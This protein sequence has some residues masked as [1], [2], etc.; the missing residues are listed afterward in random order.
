MQ[1]I[2]IPVLAVATVSLGARTATVG[3]TPAETVRKVY[4]SVT[5]SKGVPAV[6]LTAADVTVKENGK[7]YP[8]A[9]LEPAKAPMHIAIVVDDGG[10]GAFQSAVAELLQKTFGKA[11]YRISMLTPQATTVIDFTE[12][13]DGLKGAIG[14]L[15]LRGRQR[16][17]GDHLLTG[18]SEAAKALQQ[19]NA[20]RPII[21]VM[22]LGSGQATEIDP[23]AVLS[24]LRTSGASLNVLYFSGADIGEVMI[25]GPK[26]SGGRIEEANAGAPIAPAAGKLAEIL[27]KQY[28]LTYKLPDGVKMSDKVAVETS[29]KGVTLT[30]PTRIPDK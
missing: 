11:Q 4:I 22:T 14:R 28:V 15:G 2:L 19:R 26:Q 25:D 21:V 20:E 3:S 16:A 8:V 23:K 10:T 30:A 5:D 27:L 6:D 29:R 17:S 24:T 1:R 9:S 18:V 12:E 7:P 13:T